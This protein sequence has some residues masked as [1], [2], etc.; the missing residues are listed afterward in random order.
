MEPSVHL[1]DVMEGDLYLMCSDGLSDL[2][3]VKEMFGILSQ[4][5]SIEDTVRE[6]I[7]TANAR[8]GHDNITVVI[9]QVSDVPEKKD[10]F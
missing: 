1:S 10:L 8:G 4:Q 7:A 5:M 9:T 2:L 6:F 3:T